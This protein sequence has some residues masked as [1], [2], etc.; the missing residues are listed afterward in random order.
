MP[1]RGCFF[2]FHHIS[3]NL[4]ISSTTVAQHCDGW[5]GLSWNPTGEKTGDRAGI[6]VR[7]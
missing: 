1:F 6:R 4:P 3:S 5:A 2:L 7:Q